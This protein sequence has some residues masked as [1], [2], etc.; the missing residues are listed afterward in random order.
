MR[1]FMMCVIMALSLLAL[2]NNTDIVE[3]SIEIT[4]ESRLFHFSR[5]EKKRYDIVHQLE[6]VYVITLKEKKAKEYGKSLYDVVGD[7]ILYEMDFEDME[8]NKS[9]NTITLT[10]RHSA[11]IKSGLKNRFETIELIEFVGSDNTI[12][13]LNDIA[14]IKEMEK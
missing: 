2:N 13:Y 9:V 14:V 5:A 1:Q 4:K 3:E 8:I 7:I 6:N 12:F 11:F 10:I